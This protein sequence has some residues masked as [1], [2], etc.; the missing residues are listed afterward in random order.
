MGRNTIGRIVNKYKV[1][2]T[3]IQTLDNAERTERKTISFCNP[4]TMKTVT[5]QS[6]FD[7]NKTF[8]RIQLFARVFAKCCII[9]RYAFYMT[10][11]FYR[12]VHHIFNIRG[13]FHLI[14]RSEAANRG[15]R[16]TRCI[17]RGLRSTRVRP[18]TDMTIEEITIHSVLSRINAVH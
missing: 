7:S 8:A 12:S 9:F 11:S 3:I 13:Q 6:T 16:E 1:R 5:V 10:V 15:S 18:G 14:L 2:R 17:P 4:V